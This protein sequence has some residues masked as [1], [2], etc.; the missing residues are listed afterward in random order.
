MVR[1]TTE[2]IENAAQC[3]NALR[4]RELDLR[5]YKA[6]V[7][8]NL[9]A[10]LDQFDS[11]DFSDNELRKLDGF[12]LLK[13]LKTLVLN[14]NKIMRIADG[15]NTSLPNL[16]TLVLT[17]NNISELGDLDALACVPQLDFLTVLK[18]P[19]N[20]KSNYRLYLVHKLPQVRILDFRRVKQRERDQAAAL[21]RGKRGA[22]LVKELGKRAAM[23][24]VTPA[25]AGAGAASAPRT[26]VPGA[27]LTTGV[28]MAGMKRPAANAPS[29]Q[30]LFAI[31]ESI[32]R[33]RTLEEVERLN[34]LLSTGNFAGFAQQ[35]A[36]PAPAQPP[37]AP[38]QQLPAPGQLAP[39]PQQQQV[40]PPPTTAGASEA[41]ASESQS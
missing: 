36:P 21:F 32:K 35:Q 28:V 22:A 24:A 23:S 6:P 5:G 25:A 7:L 13:R 11:I 16:S 14:N 37:S 31:R 39:P 38:T 12:P 26:F 27:P 33:A 2:L 19:V 41:P 17:G 30:D 15:L 1:L 18:N 29:T 20:A 3:T 8:E 10:T 4:D 40:L 34:Q 9:G